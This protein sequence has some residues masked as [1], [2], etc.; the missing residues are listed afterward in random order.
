[1]SK[2]PKKKS[3]PKKLYFPHCGSEIDPEDARARNKSRAGTFMKNKITELFVRV[4]PKILFKICERALQKLNKN[5]LECWGLLLGI[6][7]KPYYGILDT[8]PIEAEP[9]E[10][11]F[12]VGEQRYVL[13]NLHD[14][15]KKAE[16]STGHKL[17]GSFHSHPHFKHHEDFFKASPSL[18]DAKTYARFKFGI[19]GVIHI[20]SKKPWV[21][22][23]PAAVIER[24]LSFRLGVE[25]RQ[26]KTARVACYITFWS[27]D[28]PRRLPTSIWNPSDPIEYGHERYTLCCAKFRKN[29]EWQLLS[30]DPVMQSWKTEES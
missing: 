12:S 11:S 9:D 1:M 30:Y 24:L 17:L 19:N 22:S 18:D 6:D 28:S 20:V 23:L 29:Q 15:I 26:K 13:P 7:R 5:G 2:K 21:E 10:F 4:P 3:K 27:Y 25:D 8:W 16:E 14:E